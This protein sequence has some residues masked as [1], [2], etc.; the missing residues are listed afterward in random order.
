MPFAEMEDPLERSA[1]VHARAMPPLLDRPQPLAILPSWWFWNE[2]DNW[3]LIKVP[4]IGLASITLAVV[5]LLDLPLWAAFVV[6]DV[7]LWL[8]L[9]LFERYIRRSARRRFRLRPTEAL[10]ASSAPDAGE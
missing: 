7:V 6:S 10:A 2:R 5:I 3:A 9:G 4:F 1:L 8:G